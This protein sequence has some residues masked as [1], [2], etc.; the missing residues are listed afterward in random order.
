MTTLV[1]NFP[2]LGVKT[3]TWVD[4]EW[5]SSLARTQ[6]EQIMYR[7]VKNAYPSELATSKRQKMRPSMEDYTWK[8]L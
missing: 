8:E 4:D 1:I 5:W 3:S 2:K 6:Q 7:Y